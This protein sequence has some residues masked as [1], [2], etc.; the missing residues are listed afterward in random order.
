MNV[1]KNFE[2]YNNAV[3]LTFDIDW[4]CDD[5]VNETLEILKDK[6]VPATIFVTHDSPILE[7]MKENKLI[8]L[9][10]HP[11]FNNLIDG[12]TNGISASDI[13]ELIK[14]IVPNAKA[15]RS[16]S[17]TQSSRIIDVF[18]K[19]GLT[20]EVNLFIPEYSGII[21]KPYRSFN[22]IIRVPYKWE[23]SAQYL[24]IERGLETNWDITRFL[25][26]EGLKV[27]NFHP[28]HIF[29]NTEKSERYEKSRDVHK[30][31]FKLEKHRNFEDYGSKNFLIDLINEVQ[32]RKMEFRKICDIK[33]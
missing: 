5:V 2:E 7:K 6:N 3:F 13:I 29:L 27:F 9:G 8:E 12:E 23:D 19:Y 4:A 10:I 33:V 32:K 24:A 26:K 28:I 25:D 11:N 21:L 20:H 30:D 15:V 22:G 16:H 17:L 14:M 31:K 1:E 18:G